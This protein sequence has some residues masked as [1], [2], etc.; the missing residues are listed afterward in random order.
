MLRVMNGRGAGSDD[1]VDPLRGVEQYPRAGV[2]PDPW[3]AGRRA[4]YI[5][6]LEELH[7]AGKLS[8]KEL[9][10]TLIERGEAEARYGVRRSRTTQR[11]YASYPAADEVPGM[12]FPHIADAADPVSE[13][14][15]REGWR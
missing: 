1:V 11:D 13:V 15:P 8:R 5:E 6:A 9:E 7:R 12:A 10:R 4:A 2:R 3:P 14:G